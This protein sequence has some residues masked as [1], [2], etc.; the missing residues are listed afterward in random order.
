[1]KQLL[2][3]VGFAIA[4]TASYAFA[5]GVQ[6]QSE[7]FYRPPEDLSSFTLGAR[8][9]KFTVPM[10]QGGNPVGDLTITEAPLFAEFQDS[11]NADLSFGF[12]V[13]YGPSDSWVLNSYNQTQT[14]DYQGLGDVHLFL[15]GAASSKD[16]MLHYGIDFGFSPGNAQLADVTN[17]GSRNSGGATIT[18]YL[19]FRGRLSE[20]GAGG[21]KIAYTHAF[22]RSITNQATQDKTEQKNNG[23]DVIAVSP[24]AEWD[25]GHGFYGGSVTYSGV[26][27]SA[28]TIPSLPGNYTGFPSYSVVSVTPY[29]TYVFSPSLTAIVNV[30]YNYVTNRLWIV[31][32]DR[33]DSQ[34]FQGILAVR[35]AF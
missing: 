28:T 1:M 21:I 32:Y 24:F 19:G 27:N 20:K 11:I 3:L 10:K 35:T 9:A 14:L 17:I 4:L 6:F 15:N 2:A 8:Y 31:N 33:A 7:Y 16:I 13:D 30:G 22:E 23:G 5:E 25:Y 34:S 26:A 29:F 18:P 12:N